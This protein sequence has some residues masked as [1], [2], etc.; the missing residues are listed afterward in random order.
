MNRWWRGLFCVI[1][2]GLALKGMWPFFGADDPTENQI[3]AFIAYIISALFL[4]IVA[5]YSDKDAVADEEG[6]E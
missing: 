6:D 5:G 1:A 2:V 3:L 4:L